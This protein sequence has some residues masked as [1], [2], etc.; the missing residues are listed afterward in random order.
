MHFLHDFNQRLLAAI[1]STGILGAAC[2][3]TDDGQP[4]ERI[5]ENLETPHT[6]DGSTYEESKRKTD[7]P[8]SEPPEPQR[9]PPE[10]DPDV[11]RV[12]ERERRRGKQYRKE[13]LQRL[14]QLFQQQ[15][16]RRCKEIEEMVL[17]MRALKDNKKT[18][19]EIVEIFAQFWIKSARIFI[20]DL[21]RGSI[22]ERGAFTDEDG[23]P[24]AEAVQIVQE[25][26]EAETEACIATLKKCVPL[27]EGQVEKII[28]GMSFTE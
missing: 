18:D 23:N 11:E 5:K 19:Q 28:S 15:R 24:D 21:I 9:D 22:E 25:A 8:R 2:G 20:S 1:L 16:E 7:P 4:R 17:R 27:P 12:I 3:K 13:S 26:R 10:I 14:E 6:R